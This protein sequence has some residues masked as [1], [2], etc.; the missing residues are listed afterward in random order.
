MNFSFEEEVPK[1]TVVN[2]LWV[3]KYRPDKLDGYIGNDQ[4]KQTVSSFITRN[5][6]PHLLFY[7]TAGTG[8][9][10]LAKLITKNVECDVLYINASDENSVD[11]VRSKIKG[12]ASTTGFTSLKVIILDESDFLSQEAQAALRNL[13]E[14]FSLT[15]RFI[16]TCN[17]QE[18]IIPALISR[19]QTYQINPISKKEVAIHLKS[20]FEKESVKFSMEDLGYIVNTYYPDIRKIL[21]F[22]QQSVLDGTI[23]INTYDAVG[24]D[25]KNKIISSLSNSNNISTTFNEIRQIVA[26]NDIRSFDE[27]YSLLYERCSDYSKGKDVPVII[28]I[29]EYVHQSSLVVDKEITFMACIAAVLKSIK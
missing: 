6:I 14:T 2:S 23:K 7:G 18:K 19:C 29:A 17:Y 3:E 4:L 24:T 9:T 26:D 12:F 25:L 10:T 5:D 22:S 21:N 27:Y 8:K 1:S 13:M 15:T 20:I 11:T 16:L 28:T